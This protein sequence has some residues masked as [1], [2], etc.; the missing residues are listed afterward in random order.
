VTHPSHHKSLKTLTSEV[1]GTSPALL[2]AI[3]VTH[4]HE[5]LVR[6]IRAHRSDLDDPGG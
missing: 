3:T 5:R 1:P 6:L 2:V 4:D